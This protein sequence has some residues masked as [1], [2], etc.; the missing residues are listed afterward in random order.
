MADMIEKNQWLVLPY[1]QV[2]ALLPHLRISPIGVVPQRDRR[3]RTIVDYSFSGVNQETCPIAPNEAMQFG[4]VLHRIVEAIV[5]ANPKFGPVYL[6]KVDIADGFYQVEVRPA[7]IPKLG[8]IIPPITGDESLIAFPLVLPMGWTNSP[9]YFC[10]ITETV[11]DVTNNKIRRH[12]QQPP[13][14]LD[15]LANTVRGVQQQ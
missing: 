6:C 14:R 2:K 5:N 7:D 11:A 1:K 4:T 8:V 13:H 3:P 10:A 9:P 12:Q 15:E